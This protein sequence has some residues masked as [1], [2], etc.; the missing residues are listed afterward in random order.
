MQAQGNLPEG[1]AGVADGLVVGVVVADGV[2]ALG[3]VGVGVAGD[4]GVATGGA[5][6]EAAGE[7]ADKKK[8]ANDPSEWKKACYKQ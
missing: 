1:V 3:T 8:E 5:T 6:G 2:V 7:T 4:A